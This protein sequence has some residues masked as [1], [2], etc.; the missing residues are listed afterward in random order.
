LV[1]MFIVFLFKT[2]RVLPLKSQ[3]LLGGIV[4]SSL[5]SDRPPL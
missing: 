5:Y 3:Q 1:W 2:H 4:V